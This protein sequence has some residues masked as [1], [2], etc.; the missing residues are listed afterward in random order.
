MKGTSCITFYGISTFSHSLCW[1]GK[2]ES[3]TAP[4]KKKTRHALGNDKKF[5][6]TEILEI[7][8]Y[9]CNYG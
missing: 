7:I 8:N 5:I 2:N 1:V 4:I 6:V 9:K 3:A